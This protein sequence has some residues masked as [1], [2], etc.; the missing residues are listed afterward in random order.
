MKQTV[1]LNN[2]REM[3]L[4]GLGV[5]KLTDH[6]E[7]ETAI[8]S[9]IH[10]GYR[11]IDTASVYKNEELVGHAIEKSGI[12]R[13]ELFLTTKVWNTAQRLGD[14]EGS[15][16][17]SLERLKTDYVDLYLIHWPVPGCYTGTWLEME[18]LLESGRAP[19]KRTCPFYRRQQFRDPPPGRIKAQ[20]RK[21]SP[22]F[23]N[24]LI[25]NES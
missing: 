16:S 2:N 20:Y 5:Y 23:R 6:T 3:P 7:A 13:R 21:E 14:I 12:S 17:R 24:P 10:C 18:K 22:L 11:L 8:S 25:Q 15:L 19:G 9:A 1:F 4:L